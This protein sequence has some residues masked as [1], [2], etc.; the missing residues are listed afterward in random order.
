MGE[1]TVYS[2]GHGNKKID[3][4]IKE[5]KNFEIQFLLDIRSKPFS[6][7]N[8]Q[9]NQNELK[10][11]LEANGIKYVFVGDTLGGLPVDRS[12]YDYNG[13]VVYDL[14]K[15]KNFF[16]EGLERLTTAYE[17]QIKLAIMCSESKP[18]ECHRSKLIGQELLKKNISLKHIVSD[19]LVKSQEMVM[20]ELTKGKGTVDLFGNEIDFTSRKSY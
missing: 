16:K 11:K 8:P 13:K 20:A 18:E 19:K 1:T 3:D 17:K 5:L 9:F 14:I 7:W 2:I 6:K 12:C 10:F 4:F 15:E